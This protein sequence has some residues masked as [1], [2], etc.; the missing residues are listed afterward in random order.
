VLVAES[1]RACGRGATRRGHDGGML[2][3]HLLEWLLYVFVGLIAI[4]VHGALPD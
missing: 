3:D 2:D 4:L 1:S